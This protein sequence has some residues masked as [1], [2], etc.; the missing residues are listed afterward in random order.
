M[1]E[2]KNKNKVMTRCLALFYSI[3]FIFTITYAQEEGK[4]TGVWNGDVSLGIALARGNSNTTNISLS[5]SA[6]KL[7]TKNLE[8]A[9]R[10]SYLLGR[11]AETTN[12]ESIELTSAAKWIHTANLFSLVEITALQDKFKNFNYRII[13]HLGIGYWIIRR[14]KAEVSIKGGISGVFTKYEDTGERDYFTALMI[15]NEL[16]WKI[17]PTAEFVQNFTINSNFTRLNNYFTRLEMSLS[18]AIAK[19]WAIKLSLIDKYESL[20]PSEDIKKNDIIFLTNL[21]WKF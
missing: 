18:A 17:S 19:G 11:T 1:F 16:K 14:D 8:W 21:S 4:K 20:P 7:F 15:G 10:G 5:F 12:S 3:L 6:E 13:P 2:E 9:T